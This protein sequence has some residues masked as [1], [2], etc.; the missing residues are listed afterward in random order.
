MLY[1]LDGTTTKSSQNNQRGEYNPSIKKI[2]K[3]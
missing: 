2:I 3:E 1:S